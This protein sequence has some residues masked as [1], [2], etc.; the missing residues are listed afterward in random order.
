MWII[1]VCLSGCQSLQRNSMYENMS[2]FYP[3]VNKLI[4]RSMRWLFKSM[5]AVPDGALSGW[6][7]CN[8]GDYDLGLIGYSI[9]YGNFSEQ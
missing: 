9:D 4:G 3:V 6:V 5:S 7:N 1:T 8:P 2:L